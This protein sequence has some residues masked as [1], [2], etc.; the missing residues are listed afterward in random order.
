MTRHIAAV[1]LTRISSVKA[2]PFETTVDR[3]FNLP[4]ELYV[5]TVGAYFA[6][7]AV[8][9]AAFMTGELAIPMVICA[10]YL[11]MAFGVPMLWTAMN[12]EHSGR[13]LGW[14]TFAN[15]GI[16]THTGHL[17]AGE[18]SVQVLI[19]PLLVLSWGV[20]VAV[21]VKLV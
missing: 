8:M 3:N 2:V 14:G 7:L 11:V 6:F 15:R 5:M 18:A 21:I 10:I 9:S 17:T 20:A 4:T 12:P 1:E 16:I 13:A 19:L